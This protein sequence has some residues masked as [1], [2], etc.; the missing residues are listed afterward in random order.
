MCSYGFSENIISAVVLLT[1][2]E[3][4]PYLEFIAAIKQNPL[5]RAVKITDLRHIS[6]IERLNK[7]IAID[8]KR[9]SKY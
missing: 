7:P 3:G 2:R 1:K 5:A 9:L 4:K 6:R 8:F